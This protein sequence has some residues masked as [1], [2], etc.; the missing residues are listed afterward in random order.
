[1][2]MQKHTPLWSLPG[3]LAPFSACE[4]LLEADH[5][6]LLWAEDKA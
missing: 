2:P 6:D 1:M 5:M 3:P 4:F